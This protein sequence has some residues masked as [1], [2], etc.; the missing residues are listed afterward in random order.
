MVGDFFCFALMCTIDQDPKSS[1]AVSLHEDL[2]HSILGMTCVSKLFIY[3]GQCGVFRIVVRKAASPAWRVAGKR[4]QPSWAQDP[5]VAGPE[6]DRGPREPQTLHQKARQGWAKKVAHEK[7]RCKKTLH[8]VEMI[9]WSSNH[10]QQ[11]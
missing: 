7:R 9:S 5:D 4:N 1:G 2:E 6:D 10:K 8:I 11:G 3:G